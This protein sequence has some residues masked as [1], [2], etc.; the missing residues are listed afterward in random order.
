MA[1]RKQKKEPTPAVSKKEKQHCI[2]ILENKK[3]KTPKL[4]LLHQ[5]NGNGRTER[6]ILKLENKEFT[7]AFWSP[8]K[9]NSG[10]PNCTL[11]ITTNAIPKPHFQAG[12]RKNLKLI[13]TP[14]CLSRIRTPKFNS[15]LS[16]Q[17]QN[18]KRISPFKMPHFCIPHLKTK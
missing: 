16:L 10:K 12:H 6:K 7:A 5:G 17:D 1:K 18:S 14:C 11:Q 8:E 15:M 13:P 2:L 3:Q 9:R 4:N